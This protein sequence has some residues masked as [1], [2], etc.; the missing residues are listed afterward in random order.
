MGDQVLEQVVLVAREF[1]R[2]AVHTD[3]LRS[4][5]ERIRTAL[6]NRLGLRIGTAQQHFDS[7]D[8]LFLLE[9]LDQIVVGAGFQPL[10][11]RLPAI[12]RR[13]NQHRILPAGATRLPNDVDARDI[14]QPDVDDRDIDALLCRH[15]DSTA[16]VMRSNDLEAGISQ[17]ARDVVPQIDVVL[18]NQS[19]H[20]SSVIRM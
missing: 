8:Q 2:L 18:D 9:R 3:H 20:S 4:G 1:H 14:R 19:P 6:Q 5:V 10:D 12:A 11:F 16:P 17:A 15:V 13:Q 7:G